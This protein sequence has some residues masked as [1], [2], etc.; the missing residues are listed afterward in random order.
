VLPLMFIRNVMDGLLQGGDSVG[1][2][3]GTRCPMKNDPVCW[4]RPFCP[5][6][7]LHLMFKNFVRPDPVQK[8]TEA[9]IVRGEGETIRRERAFRVIARSNVFTVVLPNRVR[10][11][12]ATNWESRR[13]WRKYEE[14]EQN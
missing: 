1:F 6:D 2:P 11:R 4:S 10:P 14:D 13:G 8:I 7:L 3:P 9:R 5:P 12:G